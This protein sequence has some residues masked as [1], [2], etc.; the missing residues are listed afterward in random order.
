MMNIL[1]TIKELFVISNNYVKYGL[2]ALALIIG[3]GLKM[4]LGSSNPIEMEAEHVIDECVLAETNIDLS[5]Y[6]EP[7][8]S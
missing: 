7:K 1:Q 3:M 5:P 8:A 6:L 2:V 4:Y